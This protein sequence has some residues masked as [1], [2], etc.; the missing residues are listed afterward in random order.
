MLNLKTPLLLLALLSYFAFASINKVSAEPIKTSSDNNALALKVGT[1]GVGLEYL[2]TVHKNFNTRLSGNIFSYDTSIDD[3]NINYDAEL[4]LKN[5][6]AFFDYHPFKGVFRVSAGLFYNGNA[7]NITANGSTDNEFEFSDR[8][9]ILDDVVSITGVIDFTTTAPY[10]GFGWGASPL[11]S[12]LALSIDIGALYSNPNINLT[13]NNCADNLVNAVGDT[14][15][16]T[17]NALQ[18]DI[19]TEITDLQTQLNQVKWYPVISLGLSYK[20]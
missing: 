6:G 16:Q 14:N 20:F 17:C 10:L 5:I 15:N 12:G 1:L 2:Y 7:F 4:S 18:T 19:D 3:T 13:L 11:G 8:T 9:Y